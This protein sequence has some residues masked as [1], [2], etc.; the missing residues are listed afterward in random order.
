MTP[1]TQDIQK[2]WREQVAF[3]D[4]DHPVR[5]MKNAAKVP[6]NFD[7]LV[8]AYSRP[9]NLCNRFTVRNIDGRGKAVS[10][11]LAE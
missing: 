10:D 3:P 2:L 5:T 11:Y 6:V 1:S 8:V 9:L 4:G 7:K